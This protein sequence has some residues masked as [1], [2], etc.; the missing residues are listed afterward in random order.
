MHAISYSN[1]GEL[2]ILDLLG[3]IVCVCRQ[4]LVARQRTLQHHVSAGMISGT[5]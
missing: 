2:S 3:S 1:K 5:L 4:D